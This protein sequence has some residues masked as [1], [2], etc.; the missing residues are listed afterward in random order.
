[1]PEPSSSCPSAGCGA[2]GGMQG[3]CRARGSARC[4]SGTLP[5]LEPTDKSPQ[6]Y[7]N[8]HMFLTR[9]NCK[10]VLHQQ[11]PLLKEP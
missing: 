6:F 4:L 7:R 5:K 8:S 9:I 2:T 3:V 1:M 10:P 11:K